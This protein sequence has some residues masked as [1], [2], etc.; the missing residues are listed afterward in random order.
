[1]SL[2]GVYVPMA[3]PTTG[4]RGE[5]DE[6]ALHEYTEWLV[7]SGIDGLFPCGSI[8]EFS[9]LTDEQRARTTEVVVDAAGDIPVLA[10]C[11]D[12]STD[13]VLNHIDAAAD[14]GADAAVVVTPYYLQTTTAGLTTFFESVADAASLPVVLY[15]IPALTNQHLSVD[16][17]AQ[18]AEHENVVGLKDTSGD[19]TFVYEVCEATPDEFGV[20]QGATELALASLDA[21]CDGLVAGPA[22]VFPGAVVELFDAYRAGDRSRAVSLMNT[23]ISP[24][25]SATSDVPTAAAIKHLLNFADRSIGKPLAPLPQLDQSQKRVLERSYRHISETAAA[26]S[27]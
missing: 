12:T 13:A 19:M 11:G 22:N 18:L 27:R 16:A 5:L 21:G 14:A 4:R 20:L 8:G 3:T 24:T 15:N 23:V 1:M 2:S 7:G 25:V 10:G 9:S 6:H 17:V 26:A